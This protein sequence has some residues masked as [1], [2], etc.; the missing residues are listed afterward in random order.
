MKR[1]ASAFLILLA[2]VTVAAANDAQPIQ[3]EWSEVAIV[4]DKERHVFAVEMATTKAQHA[5]GL[6]GRKMLPPNAGMLFDL[7]K[8]RAVNMWMKE[9]EIPLDMIFIDSDGAIV[10]IAHD[11]EP[12]SERIIPSGGPVRAIL[13]VNAGIARRL[14]IKPGD[15]LIHAI[16]AAG[17]AS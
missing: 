5:W 13:E 3:F 10:N 12:F 15:R 17:G 6:T 7:G 2:A 11:A 4:T 9:A 16:F 8:V 1:I 14:G